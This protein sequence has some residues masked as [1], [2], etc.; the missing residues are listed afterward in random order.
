[1]ACAEC[2]RS[3]SEPVNVAYTDGTREL[4]T[5]CAPCRSAFEQGGFVT[6]V[7]VENRQT[8]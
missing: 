7:S 1:M 4:V 5:L 8:V 2:E 3:D 6:E